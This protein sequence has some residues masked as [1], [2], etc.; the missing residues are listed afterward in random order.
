MADEGDFATLELSN[1]SWVVSAVEW[2]SIAKLYQEKL[3]ILADII[4]ENFAT[5]SAFQVIK[6]KTPI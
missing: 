1:D 5:P 3:N 2:A 6:Y 4:R